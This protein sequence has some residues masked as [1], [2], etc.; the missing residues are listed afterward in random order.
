[1]PRLSCWFIRMALLYFALGTTF[2]GLILWHKGIPLN[3]F[4]WRLLPLHIE[5]LLFGWVVQLVMGVGFWI[6][7]RFW[8]SRGDERPAWVAFWLLNVGVWLAGGASLFGWPA[9]TI[10]IGR[11]AEIGAALA[12]AL[13][14]WPRIK[15]PG[16]AQ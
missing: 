7:P 8:R 12:F 13:H 11:L 4:I 5:L 16:V 2:G 15:P 1:M 14:A 10:S 3:P 6:F 9:W